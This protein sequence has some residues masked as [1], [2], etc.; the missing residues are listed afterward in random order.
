MQSKFQLTQTYNDK[1]NR[2]GSAGKILNHGS[3]IVFHC[4]H[5]LHAES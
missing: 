3:F 5:Y 4:L 2:T 1:G